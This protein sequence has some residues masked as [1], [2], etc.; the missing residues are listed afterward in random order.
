MKWVNVGEYEVTRTSLLSLFDAF[1]P[2]YEKYGEDRGLEEFTSKHKDYCAGTC[3]DTYEVVITCL[4]GSWGKNFVW[5][6]KHDM[7]HQYGKG[8]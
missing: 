4:L 7:K 1:I 2:F 8:R 3:A 6:Y 5:W